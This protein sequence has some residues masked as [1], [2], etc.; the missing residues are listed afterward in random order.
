MWRLALLTV[1]PSSSTGSN[2]AIGLISPVLDVF[3]STSSSVVVAKSS[4]HLK[5]IESLGNFEVS[6]KLLLYSISV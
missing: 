6:P 2:I 1:V 5:A 4:A 3:H